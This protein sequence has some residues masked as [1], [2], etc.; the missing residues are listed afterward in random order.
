MNKFAP[1]KDRTITFG[2]FDFDPLFEQ[3]G[4]DPNTLTA[5][6]WKRFEDMFV[7]GT[8]WTEVAKEAAWNIKT[9]RLAE[10]NR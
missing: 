9:D 2:P 7:E 8:G 6:E 3:E 4:I 10:L 1:E 5:S